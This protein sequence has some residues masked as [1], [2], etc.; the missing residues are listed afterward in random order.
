MALLTRNEDVF[1]LSGR[2]LVAGPGVSLTEERSADSHPV[3]MEV[4]FEPRIQAPAAA[5][6]PI[7][8][9]VRRLSRSFAGPGDGGAGAIR[10]EVG[11]AWNKMS[12]A[13]RDRGELTDF[14][15]TIR[16]TDAAPAGGVLSFRLPLH[17]DL[18]WDPVF[19]PVGAVAMRFDGLTGVAAAELGFGSDRSLAMAL[20][21]P[22]RPVAHQAIA[23]RSRAQPL[24]PFIELRLHVRPSKDPVVVR[25]GRLFAGQSYDP[26][27]YNPS[28]E[29]AA[30]VRRRLDAE[31]ASEV[32][33]EFE[34]RAREASRSTNSSAGQVF[35]KPFIVDRFGDPT[36]PMLVGT[37]GSL[38]WYALDP[39]HRIEM[40]HRQGYVRPGDVVLDCGAHAGQMTTLFALVAGP[41]GKVFAFEPFPQ[42]YLQVE[43]QAK[44]NG[45]ANVVATR[46]GVGDKTGSAQVPVD[47]QS[48]WTQ[49]HTPDEGQMPIQLM[50]LDDF[51]GE[52][53]TFIKLDV[54]GAEILALRGAQR[55]LRECKPRIFIEVHTSFFQNFG[56]TL[57]DLFQAIPQDLYDIKA[58]FEGTGRGWQTYEP[59]LEKGIE[60][61]GLIWATPR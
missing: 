28:Y 33:A 52:K 12:K 26:Y 41:S 16:L 2:E 31:H 35:I 18:I 54:E 32:L 42:N 46:A 48:T 9:V 8:G 30:Q 44:L 50:A 20:P 23:Y 27:I 56:L 59:G 40:Y 15:A 1:L 38:S 47:S 34:R 60:K 53:P 43:A 36:F 25:L 6:R 61:P 49:A 45:L 3:L 29:Y 14:T 7:Q 55:L 11:I 24:Q 5:P 21:V 10:A 39:A 13:R 51:V 17:P 57:S 19:A 22:V 58:T 4:I 37:P